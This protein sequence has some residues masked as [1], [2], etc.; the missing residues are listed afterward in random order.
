MNKKLDIIR[1]PD[2]VELTVINRDPSPEEREAMSAYIA[3][4]KAEI[5]K[6]KR[7]RER[8]ASNRASTN[9]SRGS[10]TL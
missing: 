8:A 1:E 4:R 3:K 7:R 5:A 10:I 2:G 9:V 6:I